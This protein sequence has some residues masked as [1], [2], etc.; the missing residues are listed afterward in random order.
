MSQKETCQQL[1]RDY[2]TSGVGASFFNLV[3]EGE[4][5]FIE[6]ENKGT[7]LALINKQTTLVIPSSAISLQNLRHLILFIPVGKEVETPLIGYLT[8]KKKNRVKVDL[9]IPLNDF[10]GYSSAIFALFRSFR[11]AISDNGQDEPYHLT[12]TLKEGYMEELAVVAL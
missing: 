9:L 8:P 3:F 1:A 2:I 7:E 4:D 10:L 5:I 12:Y 11:G 6:F